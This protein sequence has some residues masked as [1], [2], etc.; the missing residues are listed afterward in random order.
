MRVGELGR[1]SSEDIRAWNRSA[2]ADRSDGGSAAATASA[3]RR[4]MAS[5][6]SITLPASSRRRYRRSSTWRAFSPTSAMCG[7]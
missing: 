2:T 5:G 3:T 7:F 1:S 6:V 4:N